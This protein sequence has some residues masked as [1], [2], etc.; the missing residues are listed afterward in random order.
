MKSAL[1]VTLSFVI[2]FFAAGQKF[3]R[4]QIIG[5]FICKD[6]SFTKQVGKSASD[7]ATIAKTKSGLVNSRFVFKPNGLFQVRL[8]A[9]APREFLELESMN[10]KMWHIRAKEWTAFVGSLDEDLMIF[11]V[12]IKNGFYYFA[13]EDTPLVLKMERT[14]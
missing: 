8:P 5:T 1:L 13:I 12:N 7:K 2:P 4:E 11:K 6:V 10:N 9:S 3:G 14:R